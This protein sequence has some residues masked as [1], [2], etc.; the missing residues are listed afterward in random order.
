MTVVH[1]VVCTKQQPANKPPTHAHIVAIGTSS[2]GVAK[3]KMWTVRE[4]YSA[5]DKGE[6]FYTVSPSS[7]K[8][9]LVNKYNCPYCTVD[10]LRSAPDAEKDNN[11]DSLPYCN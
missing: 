2:D 5:M 7:S 8:V 1:K 6:A 4:A 10:T 3:D 9:A 11:L